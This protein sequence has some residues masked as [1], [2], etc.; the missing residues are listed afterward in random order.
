M[1][2][3]D[4]DL[5]LRL[6][7]GLRAG[8]ATAFDA[9]Y[10]AYNRRLFSFLARLSSSRD[11][12]ED[13]VEEAWVRLVSHRDRLQPDTRL[14]P[15]LFT[16][17]RNLYVSH[18]RS[19]MLEDA[20]RPEMS[21]WPGAGLFRSPFEE[22]A[23]TEFERQL[24]AALAALPL[25]HREVLL[26]VG[27]EGLRPAEAAAVCGVSPEAMRQ[28]LSRA[29]SLLAERLEDARRVPAAIPREVTP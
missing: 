25:A 13:L 17:A 2:G 27:I 29:R 26:L 6:V 14:G 22:T 9:V 10:A 5:E 11:V 3:M 4:R 12:A 16:V 28:R 21:D 15:W 24:E 7:A 23:A 20:Y 1:T 18:R 19:R 8:D